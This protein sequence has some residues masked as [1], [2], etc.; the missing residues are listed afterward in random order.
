MADR[1]LCRKRTTWL[2]LAA[3]WVG[4]VLL[5]AP[6]SVFYVVE[7]VDQSPFCHVAGRAVAGSH[8]FPAYQVVCFAVQAG[9]IIVTVAVTL[10]WQLWFTITG[11][12]LH[13]CIVS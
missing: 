4:S 9:I 11:W 7:Q 8:L 2:S 12:T 10:V 13:C 6:Q 5:A 1:L 3:V